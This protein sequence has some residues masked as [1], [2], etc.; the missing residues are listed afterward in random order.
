[1]TNTTLSFSQE[2]TCSADLQL[3]APHWPEANK[4]HG[5]RLSHANREDGLC[6]DILVDKVVLVLSFQATIQHLTSFTCLLA[7]ATDEQR[8]YEYEQLI[9]LVSTEKLPHRRQFKVFVV[10]VERLFVEVEKLKVWIFLLK[11]DSHLLKPV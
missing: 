4:P 8:R 6:E 7:H 5:K 9:F 2:V 10:V 11:F 3:H 1:M